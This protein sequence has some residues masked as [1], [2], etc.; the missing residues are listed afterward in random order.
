MAVLGGAASASGAFDSIMIYGISH[1]QGIGGL[2]AWQWTFLL[3]SLPNIPLGIFT[4]LLLDKV[5]NAVQ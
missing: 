3:E 1:M 4:Y 5:P 2:K